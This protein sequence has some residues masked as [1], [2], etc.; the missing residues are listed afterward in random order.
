MEECA[1][2]NEGVERLRQLLDRWTTLQM[3]GKSIV[4]REGE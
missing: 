1:R 3:F 2:A 4:I